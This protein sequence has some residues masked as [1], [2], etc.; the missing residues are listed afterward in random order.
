MTLPSAPSCTAWWARGASA[1]G[2]VGP[3]SIREPPRCEQRERHGDRLAAPCDL[4][5]REGDRRAARESADA[6][7]DG[8]PPSHEGRDAALVGHERDRGLERLVGSCR[9]DRDRDTL[10]SRRTHAVGEALAVADGDRSEGPHAVGSAVGGRRDDGRTPQHGVLD[11]GLADG[12]RAAVEQ[13][14]VAGAARPASAATGRRCSPGCRAQHPRRGSRRGEA[15]ARDRRRPRCRSRTRPS[16]SKNA[17]A[18]PGRNPSTPSPTAVT[19][20][21]PSPPTRRGSVSGSDA[22]SPVRS[23]HSIG[24]TPIAVRRIATSPDPVRDRGC[25][26]DAGPRARRTR[27]TRS[28]E[29]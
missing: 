15:D 28:P 9:I 4:L 5:A 21:A 16:H 27:C 25:R 29:P 17:T 10:R 8:I 6:E 3:S 12:A 20:P 22:R 7:V 11:D 1:R 19:T 2:N 18:S 24:L 26:R 13:E 14:G 23:F